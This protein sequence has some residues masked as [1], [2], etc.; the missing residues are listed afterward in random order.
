MN[1][2]PDSLW[3]ML[4]KVWR[5]ILSCLSSLIPRPSRS[6]TF[7]TGRR[8]SVGRQ[9][10]EGGFSYVFEATDDAGRKYALKR[11][12]L[13]DSETLVACRKE[14]GLHRSVR[15]RNLMP[16]LGMT[17]EEGNTIC[18]MLFP[19][20]P[21]SLR[22]EVNR[23]F[24]SSDKPASPWIEHAALE[25]F[26]GICD[27][28]SALHTQA[29]HSHRDLKLENVLLTGGKQKIP[30]IMDFGSA[31]PLVQPIET[32]KQVL[33]LVEDAASHTTM[34][35]RPPELLEGGV[36]AGD[37]DVDFCAVDVWSLGCTLFAILFGAS[38]FECEF[39]RTSGIKIVDCTSLRILGDLP[40]MTPEIEKWY[41]TETMNLIQRMLT[42]D[43]M[44]RPTLNQVI[45]TVER[46]IEQQGGRVRP[47][48]ATNN[49]DTD[50]HMEVLWGNQ[51][52]V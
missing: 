39:V 24:F 36:R 45:D 30:I 51:N 26:L 2:G 38:P 34:P 31:G 19:Y 46:L 27:G 41:S 44:K 1:E 28:V 17:L 23:R 43:R 18:Y 25:I 50:D 7:D 29:N 10:A 5:W 40:R 52:F 20:V 21:Y 47:C 32:R 35:Y 9:I 33:Q 6:I 8:V 42:Q 48:S 4:V 16:L 37:A 13:G 15:H 12:Y 49:G 14:A 3:R 11:I 22:A